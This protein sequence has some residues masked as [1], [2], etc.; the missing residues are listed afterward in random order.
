MLRKLLK[1]SRCKVFLLI[2]LI[3]GGKCFDVHAQ[4]SSEEQFYVLKLSKF[5]KGDHLAWAFPCYNDQNWPVV[6]ARHVPDRGISWYRLHFFLPKHLQRQ[7]KLGIMINIINDA[8]EV[9]LNGLKIGQAGQIG[10][11]FVLTPCVSKVY[12]LP[13][14]IIKFEGENLLAI[15]SLNVFFKRKARHTSVIIGN[16][17][18]LMSKMLEKIQK[19]KM[20]ECFLFTLLGVVFLLNLFIYNRHKEKEYLFA[21]LIISFYGSVLVLE[22]TFFYETGLKTPLC[23]RLSLAMFSM[24]PVFFLFF[25]KHFF[26][27]DFAPAKSYLFISI[28]FAL[29][30]CL[31]F[32]L[33]TSV[34]F[35]NLWLFLILPS[36]FIG[37]FILLYRAYQRKC[38]DLI[39][40]SIGVFS[41]ILATSVENIMA[42]FNLIPEVTFLTLYLQ[43]Y[44]ILA[45]V[46]SLTY[47]IIARFLRTAREKER[48]SVKVLSAQEQERR[49]IASELHD[50]LGQALLTIKFHLQHTNEELQDQMLRNTVQEL[51]ACIET[52]REISMGLRPVILD[53]LGIGPALRLYGE[54]FAQKTGI[55]VKFFIDLKERPTPLIEDNL[56]RIFQESLNN[57][58]KHAE[59]HS[60]IIS[61]F[62]TEHWLVM[63][64]IDDGRGF[65]YE[66][67][68]LMRTGLGLS[69]IAERV[70]LMKGRLYIKTRKDMGTDLTIEVP[71]A[72]S[73]RGG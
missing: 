25:L 23:Q 15:R 13:K 46:F 45:F 42:I 35:F 67:E 22:S 57:I 39:P 33:N 47:S 30:V 32:S 8:H 69:T 31:F 12:P 66:K 60:V 54:N 49:R 17:W 72:K 51:E 29:S 9:Y 44:G 37:F 34:I 18:Q 73:Y 6:T 65:D 11:Q 24:L 21:C 71:Y 19:Q 41:V 14:D 40:I 20:A 64:I 7:S 4:D 58:F 55:K 3:F 43:D 26:R 1:K 36:H 28:T 63:R 70:D 62:H 56:F 16:Y 59:A 50:G 48:L 68:R 27:E 61:L 10:P 53:K 52:V 2:I 5:R 38:P